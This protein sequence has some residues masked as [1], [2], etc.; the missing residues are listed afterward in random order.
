M[1]IESEIMTRLQNHAGTAALVGSGAAAR[2]YPMVAPD[3]AAWPFVVY[4]LIGSDSGTEMLGANGVGD[5]LYQFECVDENKLSVVNLAEQ[6]R[7][8][9]NGW[10]DT[11]TNIRDARVTGVADINLN[12][13]GG[14]DRPAFERIIDVTF[15]VFE[16]TS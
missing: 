5:R 7:I 8:A 16:A 15:S 1:S 9:M 2:I 12:P 14:K 13:I 10:R 11:S 3:G 6:I 4:R